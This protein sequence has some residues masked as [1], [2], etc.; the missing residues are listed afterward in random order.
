MADPLALE[1]P[2][3]NSSPPRGG[4]RYAPAGISLAAEQAAKLDDLPSL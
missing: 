3:G 2:L 4:G 1:A